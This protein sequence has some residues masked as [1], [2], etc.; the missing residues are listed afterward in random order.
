MTINKIL[1]SPYLWVGVTFVIS[2]LCYHLAGITF[3]AAPLD[4]Y[5]QYIDPQLL[6]DDLFHSILYLHIQPPLF[7]LFL[8]VILKFSGGYASEIFNLLWLSAGLL[9]SMSVFWLMRQLGVRDS[10]NLAL[11]ILFVINPATV[12]YETWLFYTYP[13]AAMLCV[14]AMLL[15]KFLSTERAPYAAAF[16]LLL[17]AITMTWSLFHILWF[18]MIVAMLFYWRPHLRRQIL[19]SAL[20]PLLLVLFP[21][22][23]NAYL[24][25]TFSN[26][27][28]FGMNLARMSVWRLPVEERERLVG[29][30]LLSPL[31]M[32]QPF[33]WDSL[34]VSYARRELPRGTTILDSIQ[35]ST[36]QYNSNHIGMIG[37]AGEYMKDARYA[38]M[39]YPG[40]YLTAVVRANMFYLVPATENWLFYEK[41]QA[42]K[43][44]ERAYNLAVLWQL[45]PSESVALYDGTGEGLVSKLLTLSI[46][47]IITLGASLLYGVRLGIQLVKRKP[48]DPLFALT[49]LYIVFNIGYV[50][51]VSNLFEIGENCRF[52]FTIDPLLLVMTGVLLTRLVRAKGCSR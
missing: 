13:L 37:V 43:G 6:R 14:S 10:I 7:N 2:R 4:F 24:F 27:S 38:L 22:V 18:V 31:A 3:D 28:L 39:H 40:Y 9:I 42:I 35:K 52:R 33:I 25:G 17:A 21:Y 44:W 36:G 16:F 50:T 32:S 19:L 46:V 34:Y 41:V 8:G 48:I 20:L 45:K 1:S 23:K 26:N 30:K 49:T 29:E 5:I 12:L 51:L 15:R 11:V 47:V